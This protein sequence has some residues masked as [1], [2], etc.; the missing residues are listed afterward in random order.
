MADE[1]DDVI[2]PQITQNFYTPSDVNSDG[3]IAIL[4]FD[5]HGCGQPGGGFGG[6]DADFG[7][8]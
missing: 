3:K 7:R 1:F 4:V 2:Y 5:H 8:G 6:I